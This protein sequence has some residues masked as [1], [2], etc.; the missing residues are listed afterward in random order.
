MRV[1][2]VVSA[3]LCL[4]VEE[5]VAGLADASLRWHHLAQMAKKAVLLLPVLREEDREGRW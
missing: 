2:A 4:L 3:A 5:R 1:R